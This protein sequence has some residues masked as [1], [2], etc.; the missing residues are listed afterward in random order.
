MSN[1]VSYLKLK[2]TKPTDACI[3]KYLKSDYG[4]RRKENV[5]TEIRFRNMLQVH[6]KKFT[7]NGTLAAH[8]IIPKELS[9]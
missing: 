1:Q 7:I 3:D 8:Q 6:Y 2:N 4:I 5:I 9:E